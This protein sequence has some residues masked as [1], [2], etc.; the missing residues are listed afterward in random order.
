MYKAQYQELEPTFEV[1]AENEQ[2]ASENIYS[3]LID[4]DANLWVGTEKGIDKILLNESGTITEV[5]N[6][7]TVSYTHLT[8]PTIYSV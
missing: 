1:V 4:D 2:L 5:Q 8:L 6:F 3:M 7:G